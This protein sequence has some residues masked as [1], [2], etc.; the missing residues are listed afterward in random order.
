MV[1]GFV[2]ILKWGALAILALAV[3]VPAAVYLASEAEIIRRYTLPS[4]I[5]HAKL[6]PE[7]IAR[8][9]H[10]AAIFGCADCHGADMKG[11]VLYEDHDFRIAATD[12]TAFAEK[13]TDEDF[14]RAVRHGLSPRARALWVMPADSYV[15]MRSA[16]LAD[17]VSYIRSL[18]ADAGPIHEPGFGLSAR[19]AL[20]QCKLKPA[21]P[22]ELGQNTPLDVGPHWSGGRYLA[23]IGCSQCHGSDLTGDTGAPDLKVAAGYSREQFFRLLHGGAEKNGKLTQMSAVGGARFFALRDYE[24]DALYNYL[25]ERARVMKTQP[26]AVAVKKTACPPGHKR[27]PN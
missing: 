15:Y 16:D 21:S 25:V 4:S 1:G 8:G 27:R 11:R 2:K 3:L 10:L 19:L 13:A 7:A 14:D 18:P 23:A 20:L 12:L 6:T 22:Y 5:L 26:Q 9:K 17:I 24:A